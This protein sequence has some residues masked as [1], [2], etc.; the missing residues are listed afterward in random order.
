MT[1]DVL[2]PVMDLPA[3]ARPWAGAIDRYN[4]ALAG[5]TDL[6]TVWLPIGDG[7][8]ISRKIT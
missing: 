4:H 5:R 3:A 1:D 2:F 7:I 6:Q 8:A